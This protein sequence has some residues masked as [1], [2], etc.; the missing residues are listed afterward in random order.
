[1]DKQATGVNTAEGDIVTND[2]TNVQ[3]DTVT[4]PDQPSEIKPI[5]ATP[6]TDSEVAQTPEEGNSE[7]ART[8]PYDRFQQVNDERKKYK[9]LLETQSAQPE[10][11][12]EPEMEQEDEFD[13]A[14]KIVD[15]RID[16]KM[17]RLTRKMELDET[18]RAN[19]DFYKY[20]EEIK[21]KV[22]DNPSLS[23]SDAYRL[24][25]YETL[26]HQATQQTNEAQANAEK[27]TAQVEGASHQ[28]PQLKSAGE[29]DI[30]AKGPDGK[31]L[32]SLE[33]L[34]NL[35]PK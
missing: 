30:N 31:F 24:V 33:E 19:S 29:I 12:P 15:R 20:S 21:G 18:I 6:Q 14:I 10:P 23:W 3:G 8:V 27:T 9:D 32:Y 7:G 17:S 26:N 1:M 25:K 5:E 13:D 16:D 2:G 22:Q 4:A 34:A 11:E 35:L 28:K